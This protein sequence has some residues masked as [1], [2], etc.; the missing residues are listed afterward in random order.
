MSTRTNIILLLA[1]TA[2]I[3]FGV[4]FYNNNKPARELPVMGKT[5][6]EQKN[7]NG[8]VLFDTTYHKVKDFKL[9]NQEG[10]ETTLKNVEGK[11]F[12]ADFFFSN[13]KGICIKMTNQMERVYEK[14]KDNSQVMMLS[15]TVDPKRDTV[16]TLKAY[17]EMHGADVS[18]WI[19]L[20]GDK[21]QLYDLARTSYLVS[22]TE[23]DGGPQDFVHTENFALVDPGKHIRGYYD[24]TDTSDVD[25]LMRD[26]DI[27]L[28]EVNYKK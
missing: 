17:A 21:K 13:C 8:K 19:F 16:E 4:F 27:L 24:G 23:G 12:V 5:D 2:L 28:K 15:H 3:V 22:A 18:K 20:T 26:I 14:Y 11:I 9:I 10:K 25:R 1:A 7:Q 6:I